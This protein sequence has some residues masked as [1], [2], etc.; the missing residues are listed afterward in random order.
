[1]DNTNNTLLSAERN[2]LAIIISV[3]NDAVIAVDL[4]HNITL[5]NKAAQD[6]TGY[7]EA[8]VLN[9]PI[10]SLIKIYYKSEEMTQQEYCPITHGYIDGI[11]FSRNDLRL[12]VKNNKIR[13]LS[14]SVQ[15]FYNGGDFALSGWR[16]NQLVKP[17]G[18]YLTDSEYDYQRLDDGSVDGVSYK[19][20]AYYID[21]FGI[22]GNDQKHEIYLGT[23]TP[24]ILAHIIP[25]QSRATGA[26]EGLHLNGEFGGEM[27]LHV[28]YGYGD[29]PYDHSA[30]FQSTIMKRRPFYFELLKTFGLPRNPL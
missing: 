18:F 4:N 8:E 12:I 24:E 19:R 28:S 27:D 1:M 16:L 22:F 21:P 25:A 30:E 10:S 17:D 20:D 26:Q 2:K 5:F 7:N 13:Q 23:D 14:E 15:N 6:L 11:V 29:G 9:K 3:I